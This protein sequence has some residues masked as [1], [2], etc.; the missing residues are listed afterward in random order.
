MAAIAAGADL[1]LFNHALA[2]VEAAFPIVAQ[3]AR[4]SVLDATAVHASARR[5]L[6]LKTWLKRLKQPPLSIVGCRAHREL[7]AEVARRAVTLVRQ[8]PGRLPLRLPASAR[9]VVVVPKPADLTPADTSSYLR[10]ALAAALRRHHAKVDEIEMS[11]TPTAS[12]VRALRATLERADLAVIGTINATAHAGQAA[13]VN[14]VVKQGTPTIA[15]ALRMPYDL[16]AY[17]AVRTYACTYSILPPAMEALAD[18]LFGRRPF[19]GQLPVTL[20]K[21]L[22]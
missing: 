12:E 19:A 10:P 21:S 22:A 15:V 9:L 4:R 6:A 3:A 14:A 16:K 2:K 1:V 17:P 11:M 5:I 7:A 20:P 8:E 13:L 18:A